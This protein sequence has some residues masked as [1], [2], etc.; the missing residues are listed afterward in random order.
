MDDRRDERPRPR[1]GGAPKG[2]RSELTPRPPAILGVGAL[3]VALMGAVGC[4]EKLPPNPVPRSAGPQE[5]P[6]WFDPNARWDPKGTDSRI[7]IEGKIVYDTDK[8]TI[9]PESERVL[10]ALLAFM[11]QRPDVT[12]VRVEGHTDSRASDE[13]NQ[14]LSARRSLSVCNWLVDH[15][16]DHLRLIAVG[17]GESRPIGPNKTAP[18][19]QENRRTEF[20]VAEVNG[21]PF[22]N[23]D[24][25]NG[26]LALEV[27][28]A[29]ERAKLNAPPPPPPKPRPFVPEGDVI[30]E[31]KPEVKKEVVPGD[32]VAPPTAPAKN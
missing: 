21:K 30:K 6:R 9:R 3:G 13:H 20:H 31:Q 12:R 5:L 29:E 24:E 17:F 18:G 23:P 22:G 19:R 14:E 28:S 4:G 2:E 27:L 26:G 15:G 7:Y 16:V 1:N 8:A 10:V 25:T 32:Q 11:N